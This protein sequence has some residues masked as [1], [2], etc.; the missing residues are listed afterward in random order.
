MSRDAMAPVMLIAFC[1]KAIAASFFSAP[2]LLPLMVSAPF[3]CHNAE[4]SA[5][6]ASPEFTYCIDTGCPANPDPGV[7]RTVARFAG[8]V[9]GTTQ[10]SV[11]TCPGP[12]WYT[13]V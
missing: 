2:D 3:R 1:K 12:S 7:V 13:T 8:D 10:Y 4:V 5:F 9:A 6:V 11:F